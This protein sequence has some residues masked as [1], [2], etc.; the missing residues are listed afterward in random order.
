[1]RHE[2]ATAKNAITAKVRKSDEKFIIGKRWQCPSDGVSWCMRSHQISIENA[3]RWL[4]RITVLRRFSALQLDQAA[5]S[6]GRIDIVVPNAAYV[7]ACV[8][9]SP[10]QQRAERERPAHA[11]FC[12]ARP[13]ESHS[14]AF[15]PRCGLRCAAAPPA[16]I[17]SDRR[18][19]L[20]W[21]REAQRERASASEKRESQRDARTGPTRLR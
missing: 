10:A 14:S 20:R 3:L 4:Q 15:H 1:M 19:L 2:N 6:Y 5:Y 16:L 7:C 18:S 11:A 17:D 21:S 12:V 9:A 13:F 8:Q